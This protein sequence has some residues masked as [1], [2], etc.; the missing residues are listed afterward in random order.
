MY[1]SKKLT[2][3]ELGI[4]LTI[5]LQTQFVPRETL[6]VSSIAAKKLF[7]VDLRTSPFKLLSCL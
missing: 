2:L 7:E 1:T 6:D 3:R 5:A 4:P